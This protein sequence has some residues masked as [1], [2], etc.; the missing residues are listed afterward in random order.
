MVTPRGPIASHGDVEHPFALASVTKVLVADA[1]LVAV[2]EEALS[3]DQA[4][5]PPGSTVAHLLA[6]ASGL[7]PEGGVLAPPGT[8]R[9]YSNAGFEA[10]AATLEAATGMTMADYLHAA[11][12]EPLGMTGTRLDGS[13]AHGAV[14]TVADLARFAAELLVPRLLAP[15]TLDRATSPVFPDLAGVLPGFGRQEPNPWGL[16]F[17]IRGDKQPHWTGRLNSPATFGHFGHVG[18]V[19]VGGSG[20]QR[21]AGGADRSGVRAVVGRGL[22]AA[23]GRRARR[24]VVTPPAPSTGPL[25]ARIGR[26]TG[27]ERLYLLFRPLSAVKD[28]AVD[29]DRSGMAMGDVRRSQARCE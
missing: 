8:R 16:G 24:G 3:L 10:L 27:A 20:R 22:A 6:H 7:G 15:E 13:A 5:G 17:E 19:R 29:P 1:V 25:R 11:V 23:V 4:A 26:T 28:P 14:S 12:V 18:D 21:G 9:I 2:E